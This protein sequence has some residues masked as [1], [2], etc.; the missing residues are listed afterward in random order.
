VELKFKKNYD[1]NNK[2]YKNPIRKKNRGGAEFVFDQVAYDEALEAFNKE[3]KDYQDAL[4][5]GKSQFDTIDGSKQD[6]YDEYL[7]SIQPLKDAQI[8]A[9]NMMELL[10]NK[11]QD[12]KFGFKFTN[13]VNHRSIH[14]IYKINLTLHQI[15]VIF[16]L[17]H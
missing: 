11:S 16:Y 5:W 4:Y 8:A 9:W 15:G 14:S 12:E 6:E 2:H 10:R 3:D 13:F 17:L 1:Y 7:A